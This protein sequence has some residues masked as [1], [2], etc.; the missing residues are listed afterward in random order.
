MLKIIFFIYLFS[1]GLSLIQL[2]F[3]GLILFLLIILSTLAWLIWEEWTQSGLTHNKSLEIFEVFFPFFLISILYLLVWLRLDIFWII[4]ILEFQSFIILGACYLFKRSDTWTT[5]KGIEGSINYIF[6]AFFSFVLMLFYIILSNYNMQSTNQMNLIMNSILTLSILIKLGAFPVF[7][8]VPKV[9]KNICYN[10]LILLSVISK[11]YLISI[12]LVYLPIKGPNLIIIGSIS[13]ILSSFFMLGV[14]N[15]KK[16]LAFSSI[17][18]VG[19]TLVLVISTRSELPL[20]LGGPEVL[21][22]FFFFYAFNLILFCIIMDKGFDYHLF[23]M[24]NKLLTSQHFVILLSALTITLLSLS[25]LPPFS[26]FFGK[27][28]ILLEYFNYSLMVTLFLLLTSALFVFIYLRPIVYY[29]SIGYTSIMKG[30]YKTSVS[31]TM[32]SNIVSYLVLLN[33][34]IIFCIFYIL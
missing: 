24:S 25:G 22:I 11:V 32:Y 26:G 20:G 10:T 16:F 28:I 30:L 7:I 19:W 18:N 17:A 13:I 14:A 4:F 9:F 29:L 6:P 21:S 3:I 23:Y 1:I 27:Y 33:I 34:H 12:I 15:I 8:W 5:I 2:E 31:K